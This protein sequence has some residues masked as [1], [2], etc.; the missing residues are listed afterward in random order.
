M[1]MKQLIKEKNG[2][3]Y[4]EYNSEKNIMEDKNNLLI[5]TALEKINFENSGIKFPF[6]FT[7]EY[8]FLP[9]DK[10]EP[11]LNQIYSFLNSLNK[12]YSSSKYIIVKLYFDV[13]YEVLEFNIYPIISK[14]S[15]LGEK[16]RI[17]CSNN[18]DYLNICLL[19]VPADSIFLREFRF[20]SMENKK[21]LEFVPYL[22]CGIFK[23]DENGM[24]NRFDGWEGIEIKTEED[25]ISKIINDVLD[26]E[27]N[28]DFDEDEDYYDGDE[29]EIDF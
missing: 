27:E 28:N 10:N 16:L 21:F 13:L 17:K 18:Y 3:K 26:D 4:V 2:V 22:N 23:Y 25:E 29:D 15:P 7:K 12:V 6:Y 8:K 11:I 20:Y 5:Y 19:D 14:N 24:V 1:K 9:V